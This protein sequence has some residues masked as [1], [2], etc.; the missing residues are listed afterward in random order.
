MPEGEGSD[1]NAE[2]AEEKKEEESLKQKIKR[3]RKL[4]GQNV[5]LVKIQ[6]E[7]MEKAARLGRKL[8]EDRL[9]EMEG[10]QR[11]NQV[12]KKYWFFVQKISCIGQHF[13]KMNIKKSK[14]CQN[15]DSK[16]KV[17]IKFLNIY[18]SSFYKALSLESKF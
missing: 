1:S 9:Q 12:G 13:K 16:I 8:R 11:Q 17:L 7:I 10:E 3:Q 18:L 15:C 4:E 14:F 2:E 5:N 6:F